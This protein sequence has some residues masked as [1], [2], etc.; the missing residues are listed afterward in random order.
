MFSVLCYKIFYHEA[1]INLGFHWNMF[2]NQPTSHH[3]SQQFQF[4][5]TSIRKRYWCRLMWEDNE[6][7]DSKCFKEYPKL[8]ESRFKGS[9]VV[10]SCWVWV[11]LNLVP[12]VASDII[13]NKFNFHFISER[14]W[15][16]KHACQFTTV[17]GGWWMKQFIVF[18]FSF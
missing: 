13:L 7:C 1:L 3:L 12:S 16:N 14:K 2:N 15:D 9:N 11:P 18:M 17:S 5:M 4:F 8:N 10:G 6:R